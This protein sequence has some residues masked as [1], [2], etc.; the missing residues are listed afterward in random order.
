MKRSDLPKRTAY[1]NK[2]GMYRAYLW[3]VLHCPFCF[4]S[5]LNLNFLTRAIAHI[6]SDFCTWDE[7]IPS[8]TPPHGVCMLIHYVCIPSHPMS[9]EKRFFILDNL[10]LSYK[11]NEEA[12]D[13]RNTY[14]LDMTF[15]VKDAGEKWIPLFIYC[16]PHSLL[17]F[18]ISMDP[19]LLHCL[20][21]KVYLH[22][23]SPWL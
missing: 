4:K 2:K 17:S 13:V 10:T 15:E 23:I 14:R 8:M 20:L 6:K 12:A 18:T 1:L 7:P 5:R 3:Y 21:I 16:E 9:R 22:Q 19:R 11:K